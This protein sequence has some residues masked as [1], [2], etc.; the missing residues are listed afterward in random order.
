M[1]RFE[2]KHVVVTGGARGIGYEIA[3]Q[4]AE[5][6]AMLSV[7][8]CNSENL[9]T[10]E[11]ILSEFGH[12]VFTYAVDVSKRQ[13]I[14]EVVDGVFVTRTGLRFTSLYGTVGIGYNF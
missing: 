11:K 8:D 4:F 6:G 7:L 14:Y 3:R 12:P 9:S 1:K 13:D 5:E 10:T 2:N